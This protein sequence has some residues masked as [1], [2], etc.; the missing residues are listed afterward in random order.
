MCIIGHSVQ[1]VLRWLVICVSLALFVCAWY[2]CAPEVP[3]EDDYDAILNYLVHPASERWRHILDLHNEHRI[4]TTRL[5]AEAVTW[6]NGSFNFRGCILVGNIIMVALAFL[7]YKKFRDLNQDIAGLVIFILS[8]SLL[9]WAN[10][11]SALCSVQNILAV[12]LPFAAL[13]V[14]ERNTPASLSCSVAFAV[15]ATFTS[16][17]G[18]FIWPALILAEMKSR[19]RKL[20]L[21]VLG[22]TALTAL[23]LYFSL[24]NTRPPQVIKDVAQADEILLA[25]TTVMGYT[26]E[27]TPMFIVRHIAYAANYFLACV[28]GVVVIPWLNVVV[29]LLFTGVAAWIVFTFKKTK[30]AAM[31]GFLFYLL[32][33]CASCGVFRAASFMADVPSRYQIV[34]VSLFATLLY[35]LLE[36]QRF[37]H[38]IGKAT[39]TLLLPLTATLMVAYFAYAFPILKTRTMAFTQNMLLWPESARGLQYYPEEKRLHAADILKRCQEQGIYAP[40]ATQ[41]GGERPPPAPIPEIQPIF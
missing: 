39:A 11:L 12:L 31:L 32:A 13:L 37:S 8:L 34:C 9:H 16:G 40:R 38:C 26:I 36:R 4:G 19:R 5:I 3:V 24:P 1:P 7:W 28:G 6:L 27:I 23:G 30:N 14:L 15:L 21:I 18:V 33:C 41:H 35:L 22:I 10:Q 20:A 29:G 2:F 17:S 25:K